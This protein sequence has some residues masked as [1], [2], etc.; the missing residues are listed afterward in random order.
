[1]QAKIAT[2]YQR[3]QAASAKEMA[4]ETSTTNRNAMSEAE[5]TQL[6]LFQVETSVL[7]IHELCHQMASKVGVDPSAVEKLK[8][9]FVPGHN[10]DCL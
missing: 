10:Q 1:M 4:A 7:R 6:R 9:T 5:Q 2:V 3:I 8:P